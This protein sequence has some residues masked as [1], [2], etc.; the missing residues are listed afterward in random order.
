MFMG[1]MAWVLLLLAG[2]G[3]GGTLV[4]SAAPS[5]PV[6]SIL[7]EL[8]R[9]LAR[10]EST[11]VDLSDGLDRVPLPLWIDTSSLVVRQGGVKTTLWSLGEKPGKRA[12]GARVRAGEDLDVAV[13]G[14]AWDVLKWEGTVVEAP[15]ER[16]V[17][18]RPSPTPE[19][20]GFERLAAYL[21]AHPGSFVILVV[22]PSDRVGDLVRT[23]RAL[24]EVA[25][26][27]FVPAIRSARP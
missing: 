22:E 11:D 19:T 13:A 18:P 14:D 10:K 26:R 27:R 3:R 5:A 24:Q 25:P 21:D 2:C 7:P 23:L 15:S 9:L 6:S 1:R 8:M 12:V 20:W 16:P 4:L 17:P